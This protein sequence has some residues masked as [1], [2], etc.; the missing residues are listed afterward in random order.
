MSKQGKEEQAL[1]CSPSSAPSAPP[2]VKM[3]D[4][5]SLISS[6]QPLSLFPP[7][8]QHLHRGDVTEEPRICRICLESDH[9]EDMIAPCK[10]KGSSRWVHRQCLDQWRIHETD[11]AF[12]KCT[13]CLFDYHLE[14]KHPQHS[15]IRKTKY[16]LMITRD[17]CGV[18]VAVQLVICFLGWII[19]L[20]DDDGTIS[21]AIC[22]HQP[23]AAYY[24]TGFLAFLII[25]GMYGIVVWCGNDCSFH[26]T[27]NG[28]P[29]LAEHGR[30]MDQ[31]SYESRSLEYQAR[32]GPVQDSNRDI[33]GGYPRRCCVGG[34][35]C[36]D[37]RSGPVYYGG[38]CDCCFLC[39]ND[40]GPSIGMGNVGD[41]SSG[42]GGGGGDCDCNCGGGGGEAGGAILFVILIVVAMVLAMAG[43]IMGISLVVLIFQRTVQRHAYLLHKRQLTNEFQV[44]DLSTYDLSQ[45]LNEETRRTNDENDNNKSTS[46]PTHP[47]PPQPSAPTLPEDDASYL[48]QMGLME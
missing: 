24:L 31:P 27:L 1:Y 44:M 35:T 12:S 21:D 19:S 25:L 42:G 30:S 23:I 14:M 40:D 48:K 9:P 41:I 37:C 29:D 4:E 20:T 18:H 5:G 39:C 43:I 38:D 7:S 34:S 2:S 45:P 10:C 13:E 3:L 32:R 22:P 28:Y 15:K 26:D 8:Y 6:L 33:E 47:R 36:C 17:L 11:R 46:N 16:Y